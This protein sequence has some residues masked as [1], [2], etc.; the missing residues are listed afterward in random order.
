MLGSG[1]VNRD[2][3]AGRLLL[4]FVVARQV[5]TDRFPAHS[6]VGGFEN[7]FAAVVEGVRIVRRNDD[8][9]G[10]LKAVRQTGGATRVGQFRRDCDVL[11]LV[12]APVEARDIALIVAGINNVRIGRIGRDVSRFA[13]SDR[14]PIVAS[15][16]SVV[17]AAGNGH[18]GVVLLGTI[19]VVGSPRVGNDVVK[20]RGRLVILAGPGFA[21]IQGHGR[22]T[23]V[24]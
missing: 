12:R 20:L 14:I 19:H 16:G 8:G 9:R 21:A 17:A 3:A 15:N 4:R 7:R 6:A 22:A 13:A 5:G 10:P 1:V 24:G 11:H 18:S 23:V 2:G